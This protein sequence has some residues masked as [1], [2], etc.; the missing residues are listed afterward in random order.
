MSD[1]SSNLYF[2]DPAS[3]RNL[4]ILG[5][6]DNNG[7]VGNLNELEYIDGFIYANQ[8]QTNYILKIDPASG[9]VVGRLDLSSLVGEIAQRSP[10][11]DYL[12]GI[13]YN[14][15]SKTVFVTGKRWPSLYEIKL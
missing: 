5:V 10:G 2:L 12:N 4:K 14:P 15:A 1:G 7:P 11:H 8:W 9:K 3:F 6:T 13:A